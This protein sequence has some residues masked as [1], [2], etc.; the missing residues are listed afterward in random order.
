MNTSLVL[1]KYAAGFLSLF[2]TVMTA[3]VAIPETAWTQ[4]SIIW[5]F[6]GLV[7]ATIVTIFLPLAKGAW[8]GALKT[9][10]AIVAVVVGNVAAFLSEG[11]GDWGVYQWMLLGLAIG[12]VLATELGVNVRVDS[13]TAQIASPEVSS[14]TIV[15]V[16]PT[17]AAVAEHDGAR[18]AGT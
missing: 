10:G 4:P 13:A 16:D 12:T 9:G 11:V 14:A 3:A 8:A 17:A 5:Q 1:N 2:I 6:A 18:H 7:A 15:A